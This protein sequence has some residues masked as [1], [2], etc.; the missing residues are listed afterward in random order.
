MDEEIEYFVTYLEDVKKAS[1]NTVMSYR[2]D[3]AKMRLYVEGQGVYSVSAI[4]ATV[5]NSYVLYLEKNGMAA[6]TISRYIAS[7]KAFFEYLMRSRKIETDPAFGLKAPK[8]EKQMP[9][10]L[11]IQEME[12]L[13]AQ[14]SVENP[15]GCRDKAM[16][17]LLYAT[18][19]RVSELVHLN[20]SDLNLRFG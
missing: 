1:H 17:E 12:H 9:G 4:T 7:M 13:L 5:L 2:S 19:M 15:K 10:I 20:V 11:T 3:L 6:S 8:V 16:L 14:P 18:G